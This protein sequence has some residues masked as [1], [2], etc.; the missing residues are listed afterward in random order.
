MI[1]PSARRTVSSTV[2]SFTDL[3]KASFSFSGKALWIISTSAFLLG[4][5]FALAYAEEEQYIQMEREQGMIKGA[6]EVRV[7]CFLLFCSLGF[8]EIAII[9]FNPQFVA[10]IRTIDTVYIASGIRISAIFKILLF[11]QHYHHMSFLRS[12]ASVCKLILI[13]IPTRRCSPPAPKPRRWLNPLCKLIPLRKA[14]RLANDPAT[15]LS[16][17]RLGLC[18]QHTRA[19]VDAILLHAANHRFLARSQNTGLQALGKSWFPDLLPVL[20]CSDLCYT[21][22]FFTFFFISHLSCFLTFWLRQ[23]MHACICTTP[24][25]FLPVSL[26]T[27]FSSLPMCMSR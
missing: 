7:L 1:P 22:C 6:N 9:I 26:Y 17:T 11:S 8:I 2:S 21:S 16:T 10:V 25:I 20:T 19:D 13:I 3:T 23:L 4:V 24:I 27:F 5:P 14:E 15:P 18:E 12:S